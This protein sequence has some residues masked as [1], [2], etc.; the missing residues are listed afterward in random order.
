LA[1]EQAV[2]G[3]ALGRLTEI[4]GITIY[5]P[6]DP[7]HRCGVVSFTLDHVHPH[8]VASILDGENVA[9]RAGHHCA[10]PLM[11]SLGVVATTRASFYVYN[12]ESDVDR[13]VEALWVAD[14]I[15]HGPRSFASQWTEAAGDAFTPVLKAGTHA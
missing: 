9:V 12:T 5:G 3:Y 1:H 14:R 15:F 6:K 13:L 4:P 2:V 7:A 11:A 10:Q 8:D